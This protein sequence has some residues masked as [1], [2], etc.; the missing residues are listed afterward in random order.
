[1][2]PY[3]QEITV[4]GE[5][6][7][8]FLNGEYTHSVLKVPEEGGWYVQDERG[9]SVHCLKAPEEAQEKATTTFNKIPKAFKESH[10]FLKDEDK[11]LKHHPLYARIDILKTKNGFKVSEVEM[12]EPE[13][14]FLY[15][16][17]GT[18]SPHKVA[19]EKFYQGIKKRIEHL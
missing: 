9:G 5:W 17:K 1:L 6:S 8:I 12:V 4:E 3:I 19:L 10:F 7:L 2:Q 16:E 13:L 14:F 15:R 11:T 18:F